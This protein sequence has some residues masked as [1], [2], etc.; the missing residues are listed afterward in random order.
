[1]VY[2]IINWNKGEVDMSQEDIHWAEEERKVE[3]EL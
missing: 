2:G 3:E 1:V